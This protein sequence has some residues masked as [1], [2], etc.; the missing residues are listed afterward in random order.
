MGKVAN[1][2]RNKIADEFLGNRCVLCGSQKH[3]VSHEIN[4]HP[5][6]KFTRIGS[7]QFR[8]LIG[9]GQFVRLCFICHKHVHWS[10]KWFGYNWTQICERSVNGSTGAFQ[11]SSAGSNPAAHSNFRVAVG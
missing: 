9:T 11:A 6:V 7:R 1:L 10:M 4:G 3:L 5:H 8:A 2:A